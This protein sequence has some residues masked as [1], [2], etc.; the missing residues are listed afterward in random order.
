V[1]ISRNEGSMINPLEEPPFDPD[2]EAEE[3]GNL[4]EA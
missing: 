3:H 2:I 4:E 1:N